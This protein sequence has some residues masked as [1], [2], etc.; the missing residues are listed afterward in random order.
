MYFVVRKS[1]EPENQAEHSCEGLRHSGA[2]VGIKKKWHSVVHVVCQIHD[3]LQLFLSGISFQRVSQPIVGR[4]SS[5]FGLYGYQCFTQ[6]PR[7]SFLVF[8][9]SFAVSFFSFSRLIMWAMAFFSWPRWLLFLFF[10]Y[11]C[12]LN[13]SAKV[14]YFYGL[15]KTEGKTKKYGESLQLKMFKWQKLIK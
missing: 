6:L 7:R 4:Q 8:G 12:W 11:T 9:E 10:S 15:A 5:D 14:I 2:S 3:V 1:L 13:K